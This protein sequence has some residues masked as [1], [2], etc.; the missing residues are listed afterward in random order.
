M[1]VKLVCLDGPPS[2]LAVEAAGGLEIAMTLNIALLSHSL[3]I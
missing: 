1:L 2:L 3:F